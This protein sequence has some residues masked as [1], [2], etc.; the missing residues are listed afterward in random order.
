MSKAPYIR[1]RKSENSRNS[2]GMPISTIAPTTMPG[3]LAMPP[4]IIKLKTLI[5]MNTVKLLGKTVPTL[6]ANIA[7]AT[8]PVAALSVNASSL[9]RAVSM[10][11]AVATSSSSRIAIHCRPVRELFNRIETNRRH[12]AGYQDDVVE[13]LRVFQFSA[14]EYRLRDRLHPLRAADQ[15]L[16][17]VGDRQLA[18]DLAKA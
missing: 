10:P 15:R 17:P 6:A 3:L 2:S 5:E 4:T 7:P 1:K 8:P 9:A 12:Q 13:L 16:Q 18:D 14:E 11:M